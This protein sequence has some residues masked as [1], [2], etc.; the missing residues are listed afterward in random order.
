[1]YRWLYSLPE[2][3]LDDTGYFIS[4]D[5]HRAAVEWIWSGANEDEVYEIQGGSVLEIEDGKIAHEVIYYDP[6]LAP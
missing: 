2:V 1:M 5:S 6:T 3:Q 4:A